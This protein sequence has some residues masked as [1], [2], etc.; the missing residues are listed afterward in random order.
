MGEIQRWIS[1]Y[2]DLQICLLGYSICDARFVSTDNVKVFPDIFQLYWFLKSNSFGPAY[3]SVIWSVVI[4]QFLS[5][6]PPFLPGCEWLRSWDIISQ[7]VMHPKTL[8]VDWLTDN[9]GL[10]CESMYGIIILLPHS[11]SWFLQLGYIIG[12][13]A[14]TKGGKSLSLTNLYIAHRNIGKFVAEHSTED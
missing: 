7:T 12:I 9:K 5:L 11:P 13:C 1:I 2:Q 6:S 3:A 10:L 4:P 14:W 8:P